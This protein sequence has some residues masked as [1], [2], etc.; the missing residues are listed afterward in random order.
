VANLTSPLLAAVTL[1]LAA[2][3][4][5][6]PIS[7]AEEVQP[8]LTQHCVM[9]HLPGA[10]QGEHSLYPDAWASMVNVPSAQSKLLLVEPGKPEASYS[11]LKLTGEHLAAGGS[12][13]IMPFPNG[14]LAPEETERFRLWIEQ[15][16]EKN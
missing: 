2:P 12:G 11:Y 7:F 16:A 3:A 6:A 15:G 10:A 8:I 5:A 14:P 9:C 13:E 4:T 1:L